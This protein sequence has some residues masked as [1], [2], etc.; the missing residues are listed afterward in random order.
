M[1][2]ERVLVVPRNAIEADLRFRGFRPAPPGWA[3][4]AVPHCRFEPRGPM[5]EDPSFKQLIPYMAL[6]FENLVFRYQRTS[7]GGERRLHRLYSCGVG[8]HINPGDADGGGIGPGVIAAAAER[9]LD[10]E[11]NLN[12][13]REI[14][15][16]GLIND[17]ETPVGRVHLGLVFDVWVESPAAAVREDALGGGEWKPLDGLADGAEYETWSHFLI[18]EYLLPSR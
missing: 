5:E 13:G 2:S 9:E 11:V 6:R 10:E 4:A 14:R 18:H 7:K 16:A 8:G 17:D 3:E 15:F 1:N 12:C